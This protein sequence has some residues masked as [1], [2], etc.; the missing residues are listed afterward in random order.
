MQVNN[1]PSFGARIVIN[2]KG[3]ANLAA[4]AKDTA[5]AMTKSGL[6]SG[7]ELLSAPAE[8]V[9]QKMIL[10]KHTQRQLMKIKI[11]IKRCKHDLNQNLVKI[12]GFPKK[13]PD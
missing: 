9:S 11:F 6:L 5:S 1:N 8:I 7:V 4:D 13:I 10:F 2:K 3:I 12:E